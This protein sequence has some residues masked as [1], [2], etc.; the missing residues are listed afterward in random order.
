MQKDRPYFCNVM[1]SSSMTL[2]ATVVAPMMTRRRAPAQVLVLFQC[3]FFRAKP[4]SWKNFL[5][6]ANSKKVRFEWAKFQ[7]FNI[8][9]SARRGATRCRKLAKYIVGYRAGELVTSATHFSKKGKFF[10]V[11]LYISKFRNFS[12]HLPH[13]YNT[14]SRWWHYN[15]Q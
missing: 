15:R 9:A 12:M 10:L 8:L 2:K 14:S 5:S 3:T 6:F 4:K 13:V 1:T 7:E 11:L